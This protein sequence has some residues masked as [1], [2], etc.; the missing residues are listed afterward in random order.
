MDSHQ[1]SAE[2]GRTCYANLATE[3]LAY[4]ETLPME[5]IQ[6]RFHQLLSHQL[7]LMSDCRDDLATM[8]A[9][10]LINGTDV[11]LSPEAQTTMHH[12]FEQVVCG[13][14]DAVSDDQTGS[15]ATVLYTVHLLLMLFWL[16]DRTPQHRATHLLVDFT[17]DAFRL[18]RPLLIMPLANSAITKLSMILSLVFEDKQTDNTVKPG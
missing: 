1:H 11:H 10:R 12:S 6:V 2:A 7:A 8:M 15:M 4:V 5:T 14:R 18:L 13:A 3:S 16:I 9:A 17:G